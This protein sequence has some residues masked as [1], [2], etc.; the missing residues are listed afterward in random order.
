[1]SKAVPSKM[2]PMSE[3]MGA[4][5]FRDITVERVRLQPI[6]V[7]AAT[8]YSSNELNKIDTDILGWVLLPPPPNWPTCTSRK[9]ET[10]L[11]SLNLV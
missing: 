7:N 4:D 9:A 3:T 2:L 5:A 11:N 10:E 8:G 1:M 6:G